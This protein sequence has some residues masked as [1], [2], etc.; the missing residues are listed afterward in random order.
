M[1]YTGKALYINIQSFNI[2]YQNKAWKLF[3]MMIDNSVFNL[4]TPSGIFTNDAQLM[5]FS[6]LILSLERIKLFTLNSV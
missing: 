1:F 5:L 6:H 3:L 2:C 4:V